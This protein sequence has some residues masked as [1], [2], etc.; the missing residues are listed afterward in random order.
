MRLALLSMCLLLLSCSKKFDH[1]TLDVP[2]C[3]LCDYADSLEGTYRG[4]AAGS[5]VWDNP[6]YPGGQSDSITMI[7][8]HFFLGKSAYMD[9]TRMFIKLEF[10]ND[11]LQIHKFDTLEITKKDGTVFRNLRT[12]LGANNTHPNSFFHLDPENIQ[13]QL[14]VE[15]EFHQNYL[16]YVNTS[17]KL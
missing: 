17:Y 2:A 6:S 12:E 5:S 8:T 13:I 1:T 7:A 3:E 14:W 9:S 16:Y 11:Y 4:R 10:W 15:D